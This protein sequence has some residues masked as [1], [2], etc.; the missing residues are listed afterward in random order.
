MLD[1]H[2]VLASSDADELNNIRQFLNEK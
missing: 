1:H 2:F